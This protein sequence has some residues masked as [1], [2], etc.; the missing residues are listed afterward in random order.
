MVAGGVAAVLLAAGAACLPAAT[1]SRVVGLAALSDGRLVLLD[2]RRGLHVVDPRTRTMRN[3]AINFGLSVPWDIATH[4]TSGGDQ[5]FVTTR[6]RS[7]TTQGVVY[8]RLQR[9]DVAGKLTGEWLAG[10]ALALS[11]IVITADGRTAYL[12][13]GQTPEVFRLDLSRTKSTPTLVTVLRRAETLGA[14]VLDSRRRRLLAADSYLG[15]VNVV[16]LEGSRSA[17]FLE[18]FGEPTALAIDAGG[19]RLFVADAGEDRI[20]V[21][22]LTAEKPKPRSLAVVKGLDDPHSLAVGADG[23]VWVA[24]YRTPTLF[25]LAASGNLV[26]SFEPRL[27]GAPARR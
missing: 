4:R 25:R 20:F 18:G 1:D 19:D 16:H 17:V 12:T 8:G 15:T 26:E 21:V 22:D 9:F 27:I 10:P 7:S 23:S 3:L 6:L 24:S 13:G 14:L 11:G 5:I 2:G